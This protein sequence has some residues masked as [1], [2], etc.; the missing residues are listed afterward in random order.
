MVGEDKE[1]KELRQKFGLLGQASVKKNCIGN[2]GS[3]LKIFSPYNTVIKRSVNR[4][5]HINSGNG[6][7]C[8]LQDLYLTTC[9]N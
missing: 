5:N 1:A 3:I 9:R 4:L 2:C 6:R 7:H 8:C